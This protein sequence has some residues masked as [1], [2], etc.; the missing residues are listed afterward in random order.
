MRYLTATAASYVGVDL[1]AR[2]LFVCVLDQ[3]GTIK[4]SRNMPAKPEPFLKA[5]EPF[6]P[7]LLVGCECVH[8]WYWLAD[9]CRERNIP[10]ALG[11]AFG[12]KAVLRPAAETTSVSTAIASR[13]VSTRPREQNRRVADPHQPAHLGER[14]GGVRERG[15]ERHSGALDELSDVIE[16]SARGREDCGAYALTRE[17]A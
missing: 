5:V 2:T 11:H 7:D 8:S 12:I 16:V 6:V 3:A 13:R 14:A 17:S 15:C 4:L 9:T 1:H 10:F